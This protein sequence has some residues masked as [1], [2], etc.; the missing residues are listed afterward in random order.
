MN[1]QNQTKI[2]KS[3]VLAHNIHKDFPLGIDEGFSQDMVR[4]TLLDL[5]GASCRSQAL[6]RNLELSILFSFDLQVMT[7]SRETEERLS[8]Q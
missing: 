6:T 8:P 4:S 3:P 1:L 7:D 5:G 2:H